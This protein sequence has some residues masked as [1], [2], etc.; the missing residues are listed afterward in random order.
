MK[1]REMD[2]AIGDS[3]RRL[4]AGELELAERLLYCAIS[5]SDVPRVALV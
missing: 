2:P 5:R 1:T 3:R 4:D